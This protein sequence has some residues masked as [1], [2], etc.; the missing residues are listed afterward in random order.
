MDFLVLDTMVYCGKCK[1][2][3]I[4]NT[5]SPHYLVEN[6]LGVTCILS[7]VKTFQILFYVNTYLLISVYLP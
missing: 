4:R 3:V 2:V 6:S 1:N 7:E 5:S